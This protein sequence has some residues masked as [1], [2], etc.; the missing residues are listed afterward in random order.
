MFNLKRV[1]FT[2]A[3]IL[4]SLTIIGVVAAITLPSL[5]GNINER[6]WNTQRKALYSRLSQAIS[7]MPSVR[8]YGN[9]STTRES[10]GS[11]T[12]NV[13]TDISEVFITQGLAKVYKINNIC[14]WQHLG[15]CG[16]PDKIVRYG[17]NTVK[18]ELSTLAK[19]DTFWPYVNTYGL[20]SNPII[21]GA[22]FE[23]A[24][25]ESVL[26]HYNP[27]CIP[28][29]RLNGSNSYGFRSFCANFVYDLN[30]KKGPNTIGK[31]MG[32]MTIVIPFDTPVLATALPAN[33]G[34]NSTASMS[35]S[36]ARQYC[37]ER[38]ARVPNLEQALAYTLNEKLLNSPGFYS[39]TT[40][41]YDVTDMWYVLGA[42]LRHTQKT[43]T[44]GV[45]CVRNDAY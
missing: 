3:E 15:D 7:L 37:R 12:Y 5:T 24:N 11:I 28:I 40:T 39:W 4:L 10:N 35:F 22:A 2:M 36:A 25:G 13:G 33:M 34:V 38:D 42:T 23:T 21:Y 1:A 14:D 8:G 44:I 41:P 19:S 16:L 30:G 45:Q 6:T 32:F 20:T 18:L 31:D 43:S 9:V 17:N 26:V 29:N 27:T